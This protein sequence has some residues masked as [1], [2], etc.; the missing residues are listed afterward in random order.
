MG[1]IYIYYRG[2]PHLIEVKTWY[3]LIISIK[4]YSHDAIIGLFGTYAVCGTPRTYYGW[5][6]ITNSSIEAVVVDN[7]HVKNCSK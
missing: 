3:I 6:G 7:C 1:I 4:S 2:Q 5:S